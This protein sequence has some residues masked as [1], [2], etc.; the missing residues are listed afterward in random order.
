VR[1][2][3]LSLDLLAEPLRQRAEV[4]R[5]FITGRAHDAQITEL[6]KYAFEAAYVGDHGA[7]ARCLDQAEELA[8]R[9]RGTKDAVSCKNDEQQL[10]SC[11]PQASGT[12][13][14]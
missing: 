13:G 12:C 9:L 1:Q 6:A 7:A 5:P 10:A 8:A 3:D 11:R 14:P 4:L 2:F